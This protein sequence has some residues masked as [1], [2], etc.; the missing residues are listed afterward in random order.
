MSEVN[1][2]SRL[3]RQLRFIVEIDRL[4]GILRQSRLMDDSRREN[5]AEHSWHISLLAT[6]MA[7]YGPPT[8]DLTKVVRMCLVHDIV[9]IDA[10][11]VFV[12]DKKGHEADIA[13]NE[14]AAADRIFGLLPDDQAAELRALWDEFEALE[15]QEARFA[16]SM[17]RLMPMLHN[18]ENVNPS[19]KRHGIRLDQVEERNGIVGEVAP[20]LWAWILPR[21]EAA[22]ADGR[23]LPR[24]KSGD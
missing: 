20:A 4:K 7:E 18:L 12:Y 3:A 11:D 1:S 19:W 24:A 21:L 6:V 23:L 15:T 2:E 9:E 13:A 10:G 16:R 17:D 5:S 22:V 8:L 14:R